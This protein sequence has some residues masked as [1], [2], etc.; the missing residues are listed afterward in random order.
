MS[1]DIWLCRWREGVEAPFDRAEFE[2]VFGPRIILRTPRFVRARF[3]VGEADIYVGEGPRIQ[4]MMLNHVGP[5]A[6]DSIFGLMERTGSAL[7]WASRPPCLA[8]TDAAIIPH[9]HPGMVPSIGPAHVVR[10]GQE[11]I[12]IIEGG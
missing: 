11:L 5:G 9:L 8:V 7:F 6:F 1:F 3:D 10:S 4:T 12:A 2:A